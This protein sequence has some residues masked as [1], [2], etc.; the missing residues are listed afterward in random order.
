[1]LE[2]S[3]WRVEAAR[4]DAHVGKAVCGWTLER[5]LGRGPV[6]A[7]WLATRG[8]HK[9]VVRILGEAFA[10]N[11]E[12][13]LEWLRAGWAANRFHHGRVVKVLEQ[14]VDERGI[15]ALVRGWIEGESLDEAV[16]TAG[17]LPVPAALR[18]VEQLLD[19]LEIAHAHGIVH[20]ALT[21]SNVIVTPRGSA[22]LVDFACAP[23]LLGREPGRLDALASARVGPFTAPERRGVPVAALTEQADVWSVGACLHFAVTGMP[24]SL[25]AAAP[26]AVR[27][28]GAEPT[29]ASPDLEALLSVALRRDPL[30]RY[31]SAYAM[32]GDVRRV[33]AGRKP[34]LE[35]AVAP[36]PSQS[37]A[38]CPAGPP[39]SSSTR[40][41]PALG[42][43]DAS[44]RAGQW[45][46]NV[47]LMLAISALVGVATFVLVR[48]RLGELPHAPAQAAT[49]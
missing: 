47:L 16:R 37:L 42:A 21:P 30:D 46:G 38:Q 25:D 22:R 45:R 40:G 6:C 48:E 5:P 20:G 10:A 18:L 19:A 28:R 29:P 7:S 43:P 23:G 26:L 9:A 49:H 2:T 11:E 15:P 44:T 32:L 36:V 39:S 14:G 33:L 8:G 1:M 12:A 17:G 4:P 24:P 41:A 3:S 31:E 34:K 35:S 27:S 13:R